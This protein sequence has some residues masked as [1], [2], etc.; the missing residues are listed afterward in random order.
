LDLL[1]TNKFLYSVNR[2]VDK[3]WKLFG[4]QSRCRVVAIVSAQKDRANK[5]TIVYK[6]QPKLLRHI[7]NYNY[8]KIERSIHY[9]CNYE[10][11]I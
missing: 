1:Q 11:S 7:Y 3:I 8:W 5:H 10:R 6:T 2:V 4:S 9:I